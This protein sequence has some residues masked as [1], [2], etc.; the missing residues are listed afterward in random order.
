M[1]WYIYVI[2]FAL[3][4]V[5]LLWLYIGLHI[6][7]NIVRPSIKTIDQ[8]EVEEKERDYSLFDDYENFFTDTYSIQSNHHYHLSVYERIQYKASKKFVVI[9]HGYTYSH[10]G[11]LKYA[12]MMLR[13]GY[14]VI[15]YDHRFHGNSGG[16]NTTL[17]YYEKDDLK[18][19]IDHIYKKHGQDIFLGTYGESMG[20]ATVLLEQETDDRVKF[21]V[22]DSAFKDIKSLIYIRLREKMIPAF[23]FYPI[24][25]VFVWLISGA[26][27][28][29]VK[30]IKAIENSQIPMFFVHGLQDDYIP[31]THSKDMYEHYK[32]PKKLFIA[33]GKAFHARSYYH[34][35]EEYYQELSDFFNHYV[36]KQ[37]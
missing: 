26:F 4:F 11:S 19:V 17:G 23:I 20:G 13:L 6:A 21:L 22:S 12:K 33:D 5:F 35:K 27:F 14:N 2:I 30:P 28:F 15:I 25:M 32:G 7:L 37:V 34:H 9:V 8:T 31:F 1:D 29:K 36:E 16:K 3:V 18:T 24:A 10:H